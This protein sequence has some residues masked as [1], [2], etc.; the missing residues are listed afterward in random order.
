MFL[1]PRDRRTASIID[2]DYIPQMRI[3]REMAVVQ[4]AQRNLCLES[5]DR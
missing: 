1:S 5:Y 4:Q 3:C 2:G